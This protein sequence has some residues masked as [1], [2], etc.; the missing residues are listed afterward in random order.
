VDFA[1]TANFVFD[2]SSDAN[3]AGATKAKGVKLL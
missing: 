3:A 2:I 1:K